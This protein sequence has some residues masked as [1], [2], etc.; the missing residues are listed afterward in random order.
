MKLSCALRDVTNKVANLNSSSSS[1]TSSSFVK[2]AATTTSSTLSDE[3]NL[4][5]L[6]G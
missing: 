1:S 3:S 6:D 5:D 4:N 2:Y